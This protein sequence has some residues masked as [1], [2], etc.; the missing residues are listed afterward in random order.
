MGENRPE[1]HILVQQPLRVLDQGGNP[2]HLVIAYV[3][4][5]PGAIPAAEKPAAP[6]DG[7]V[8]DVHGGHIAEGVACKL[9]QAEGD[10]EVPGAL[11]SGIPHPDDRPAIIHIHLSVP[12]IQGDMDRNPFSQRDGAGNLV[13]GI[14]GHE[15]GMTAVVQVGRIHQVD[16][17]AAVGQD[18]EDA[19][20]QVV[21]TVVQVE[22]K[23]EGLSAERDGLPAL[24]RE[25]GIILRVGRIGNHGQAVL[26][27]GG[28]ECSTVGRHGPVR[29]ERETGEK[30][31]KKDPYHVF[32]PLVR[33][34][35]S[36]DKYTIFNGLITYLSKGFPLGERL[37]TQRSALTN[38]RFC[39]ASEKHSS[40]WPM[41][42]Y[43]I[44]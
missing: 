3:L 42:M 40:P 2:G 20:E 25:A 38:R 23:L 4:A 13:D 41:L 37:T 27:A 19:A 5:V 9:A 39:V 32:H 8:P 17:L 11:G 33:Q 44:R 43:T 15:D 31:R 34:V 36:K 18:A 6:V 12:G 22:G 21:R 14:P 30:Q 16:V 29:Q 26:Q 1:G 24:Q 10:P 7:D 28:P 35:L